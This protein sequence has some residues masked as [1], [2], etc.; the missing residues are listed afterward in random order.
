VLYTSN[1]QP[2]LDAAQLIKDE[3]AGIGIIVEIQSFP[4]AEQIAREG[5]QGEPFDMTTEGWINDYSIRLTR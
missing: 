2:Q 5:T 3:L 1:R 4:R